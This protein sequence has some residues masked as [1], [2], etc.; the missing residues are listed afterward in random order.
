LIAK[1]DVLQKIKNKL[2]ASGIW[3]DLY[4]FDVNRNML[5]PEFR[6]SVWIPN[7]QGININAMEKICN[8]IKEA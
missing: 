4:H 7:H 2:L 5:N 8:L 3:T 1:E 6:R